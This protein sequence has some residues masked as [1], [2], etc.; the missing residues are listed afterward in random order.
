[1]GDAAH[2]A[3]GAVFGPTATGETAYA[4]R[5]LHL[6]KPDMLLRWDKRFDGNCR[7]PSCSAWP[8]APLSVIG[9][10]P[11]RIVD[12]QVT[13]TCTDGTVLGASYRLATTL[14]NARRHS[15][16][17]LV[18]LYHQRWKRE[19]AYNALRHTILHGRVLR[20][21]DAVGVERRCGRW[22]RE[23]RRVAGEP[24]GLS[25]RLMDHEPTAPGTLASSAVRS[26][27]PVRCTPR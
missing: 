26:S 6:L 14:T 22:S 9:S 13:V 24:A 18:S 10:V 8:A 5:L 25:R 2:L 4:Q 21:G 23:G 7:A 3:C 12:A 16:G 17:A 15:A 11:V 19:S 27:S 1:M 20:P